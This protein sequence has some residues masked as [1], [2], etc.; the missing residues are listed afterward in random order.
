MKPVEGFCLQRCV[1]RKL[2]T[3]V[4]QDYAAPIAP[5]SGVWVFFGSL[6]F[7]AGFGAPSRAYAMAYSVSH[8]AELTPHG[9]GDAMA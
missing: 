4:K 2:R 7:F 1:T 9:Y 3:F 6:V 5:D 8:A